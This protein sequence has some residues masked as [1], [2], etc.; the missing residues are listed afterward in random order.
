MATMTRKMVT[1]LAVKVI[2]MS[3]ETVDNF[4]VVTQSSRFATTRMGRMLL[5]VPMGN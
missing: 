5:Q 1:M 2:R 3:G 4:Q